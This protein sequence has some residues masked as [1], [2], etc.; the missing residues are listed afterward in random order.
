MR[1]LRKPN[2][3]IALLA[4]YTAVI[5]LYFFP[6]N[7]EMSSG[8]KWA[9]VG[10]SAVILLLLWFLL[11]KREKMRRQREKEMNKDRRSKA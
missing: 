8:E 4:I 3:T 6:R 10:A 5:Y 11:R 2:L 7:N 1:F 9:T